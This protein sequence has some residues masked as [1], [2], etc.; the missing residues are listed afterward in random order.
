MKFKKQM[1]TTS[2]ECAARVMMARLNQL[3]EIEEDDDE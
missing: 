3:E 2:Q 1:A